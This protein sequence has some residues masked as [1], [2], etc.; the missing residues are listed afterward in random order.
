MTMPDMSRAAQP[1][2][3]ALSMAATEQAT[4]QFLGESRPRNVI[5]YGFGVKWTG[6]EPTGDPALLVLVTNKI[7]EES[8]APGDIVPSALD[9]G[10][11][12]DV[13]AV[14]HL[15]AQTT[16]IFTGPV[17]P[18]MTTPADLHTMPS[19][20]MPSVSMP[21][22]A[23]PEAMPTVQLGPQALIRRM[24]PCPS[25][26]SIG[27]VAVTAGTLGGVVYD[28]LP[29]A[30]V[31][32]PRPGVGIPSAYYLLSNNHVL[33]ATNA[34]ALGS[35]IVQ[36][37]RVDGGV[38][39]GDRIGTLSRFVPIQLAPTIPLTRHQNVVDAAIAA[40]QFQDATREIYFNT[41]PRG[42]RRKADVK[43]GHLVRKTGRTT[44]TTLGRVIATGAT[45]DV[46]YG[47]AGTARFSDQII[48]TA[49][50]AGGDS[51]SLVTTL[52]D[53]AVGLLFAGSAQVTI[54][55]YFENVRTALRIEIS[56]LVL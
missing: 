35:P 28:F 22:V 15:V 33:A 31:N 7:P 53:I 18:T 4:T 30:A 24:R 52:D 13:V 41:A 40:C 49:M 48:T 6:G 21:G 36:P 55:N 56:E 8:L 23:H 3:S 51:G 25:G 37:G 47:P 50:S 46:S 2:G 10:T 14:G 26:F 38:D 16:D 9:D 34:A 27:N 17:A 1:E 29:G 42:W 32:P 12:T 54:A 44:N 11:A 45:V 5:G 19:V 20:T 43:A 39:P